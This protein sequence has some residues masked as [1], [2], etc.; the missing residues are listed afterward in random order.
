MRRGSELYDKLAAFAKDLTDVGKSLDAARS[1]YDEAYKKLAQGK[2][3]AIRQAEM[4]KTL[5]VKPA[6][7][8]EQALPPKLVE[9]ALQEDGDDGMSL[10]AS[11]EDE[12]VTSPR[13]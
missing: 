4:L 12:P 1:S 5:G 8:L 7:S 13:P 6:K 10:A 9:L 2:G 3:N 11:A